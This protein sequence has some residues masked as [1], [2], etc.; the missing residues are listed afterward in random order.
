MINFD[1]VVVFASVTHLTCVDYGFWFD[2]AMIRL[3]CVDTPLSGQYWV[4]KDTAAEAC[5]GEQMSWSEVELC[6]Y[7]AYGHCPYA[8]RCTYVHGDVCD[9]CHCAVLSPFDL[10]QRQ[11][12]TQVS[13]YIFD[14]ICRCLSY[15]MFAYRNWHFLSGDILTDFCQTCSVFPRNK[16][17]TY[18]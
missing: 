4:A 8:D 18:T 10:D 5:S 1:N 12:H 11:Q 6:P 13:M 7:A 15:M 16:V 2:I 3:I 14:L 17:L 9:L